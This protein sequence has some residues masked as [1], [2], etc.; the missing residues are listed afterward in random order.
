[1]SEN[2]TDPPHNGA[3]HTVEKIIKAIM[4]SASEKELYGLFIN[5][6]TAVPV[7]TTLEE[8]GHK[9]PPTPIQA[10]NSTT[11]VVVSNEIQPK[12]TKAMDM[13]KFRTSWRQ[14]KL[15]K[16]DYVTKH[17]L[18]IHHKA[19]RPTLLTPWREV[20]LLRAKLKKNIS[21]FNGAKSSSTA[22]VCSINP[23]GTYLHH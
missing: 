7:Q 10:D 19:I 6:K 4:S 1:M 8:L 17:P 22:R 18:A 2:T 11:C 3:V 13:W 21:I 15:N 16:G 5:E 20:E 9:Q 23:I 14:G 12:A